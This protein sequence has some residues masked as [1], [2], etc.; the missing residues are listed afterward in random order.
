[1]NQLLLDEAVTIRRTDPAS[2]LLTFYDDHTGERVELSAI[3]LHNWVAKTRN[4]LRD[5][6]DLTAGATVRLALPQHW[7]TI[8]WLTACWADGLSL[9]PAGSLDSDEIDVVVFGPATTGA[10]C[11]G[12]ESVAVSLRPM[13][14]HWLGPPPNGALDYAAEIGTHGDQ[15]S[16]PPVAPDSLAW[17]HNNKLWSR[18][19]VSADAEAVAQRLALSASDRVL[20]ANAETSTAMSLGRI[21]GEWLAPLAAGAS[22]VLCSGLDRALLERRAQSERVTA[23]IGVSVPGLPELT[24]S[25]TGG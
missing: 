12:T 2:P 8:T 3:T 9:C 4:F 17:R 1:M 14:G 10:A 24:V 19:E 11:D 25:G 16:S 13:G 22:V 21:T 6:L 15:A 23:T 5:E 18:R 7:Q 20:V